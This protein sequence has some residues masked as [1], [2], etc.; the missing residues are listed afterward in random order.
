LN[1]AFININSLINFHGDP[2]LL[3][4]FLAKVGILTQFSLSG[5]YFVNLRRTIDTSWIYKIIFFI[6]LLFELKQIVSMRHTWKVYRGESNDQRELLFTVK[7]SNIFQLRTE[8]YVFL[9]NNIYQQHCDFK[10]KASW[11]DRSCT[12]YLGDSN[13]VIARVSHRLLSLAILFPIWLI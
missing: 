10:V 8:L 12:F 6:N 1:P 3:L 7:K 5:Q 4:I 2:H 13:T 11:F 9:A